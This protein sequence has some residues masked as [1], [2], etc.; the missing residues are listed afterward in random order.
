M[1]NPFFR[2]DMPPTT[3][4]ARLQRLTLVKGVVRAARLLGTTTDTVR[5]IVSGD[6]KASPE[7][8]ERLKNLNP[9]G[10]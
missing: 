3:A 9:K 5:A 7:L 10:P 8:A 4:R 2:R 1:A 6:V